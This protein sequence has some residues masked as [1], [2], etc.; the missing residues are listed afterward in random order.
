MESTTEL[1]KLNE[2]RTFEENTK[3]K[4]CIIIYNTQ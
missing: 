4:I 1:R 2:K 3:I